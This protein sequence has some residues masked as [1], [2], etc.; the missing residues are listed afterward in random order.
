MMELKVWCD[1]GQKYKFDVEPVNGRMPF[2]VNCPICG[3]SGTAKANDLLQQMA[4]FKQ[5]DPPSAPIRVVAPEPNAPASFP[6]IEAAPVPISIRSTASVPAAASSARPGGRTLTVSQEDRD[7]AV[8]E[9]RAKILWGDNPDEVIRFLMLHGFT[10]EEA[11]EKIHA[12]IKERRRTIR[13][14][15]IKKIIVGSLLACASAGALFGMWKVGFISPFVAGGVGLACVGGLWML[16]N[17]LLQ[18]LTPGSQ[19]GD[20]AGND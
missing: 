20:A 11:S 14:E 1:C 12:M 10:N 7:K 5:I 3:V 8:V 2:E 19:S 13:G 17:G 4:V 16:F 15:G 6:R 18:F 9:A